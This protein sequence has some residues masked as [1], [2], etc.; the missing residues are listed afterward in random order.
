MV[1]GSDKTPWSWYFKETNQRYPHS[2][3]VWRPQFDPLLLDNSRSADVDVREGHWVSQVL[4]DDGRVIGVRYPGVDTPRRT[5]W[6]NMVV[7]ASGQGGLL[8][9]QLQL[10][11]WDLFFRNLAGYG[12]F[13]GVRRLPHPDQTNIFIESYPQGWLWTIPLHTG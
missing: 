10:R 12:Y 2:Y 1:W 8:A 4:F 7:D 6:A 11:Q 3:Q 5:A 13:D 9:H